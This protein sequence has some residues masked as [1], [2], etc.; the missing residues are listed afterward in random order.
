VPKTCQRLV[1]D[2]ADLDQFGITVPG[3]GSLRKSICPSK[4]TAV[5]SAVPAGVSLSI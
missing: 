4:E 5:G 1:D 2:D 3:A